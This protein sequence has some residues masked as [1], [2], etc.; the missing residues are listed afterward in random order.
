[1]DIIMRIRGEQIHPAAKPIVRYT[2]TS[3]L[4]LFRSACPAE[5]TYINIHTQR[6]N[7]CHTL[8]FR[9]KYSDRKSMNAVFAVWSVNQ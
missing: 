7:L 1:M 6:D 9:S 2:T 3:G 4:C 8:S 5:G